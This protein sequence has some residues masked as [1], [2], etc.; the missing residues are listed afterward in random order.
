M[1]DPSPPPA[2]TA[3]EQFLTVLPRDEALA[4]FEAAL[5][6]I[7]FATEER[8]LAEALGRVLAEDIAAPVDVPPFDRSGVDGFAVRAADLAEAGEAPAGRAFAQ[9]R[10]DRLRP[11]RGSPVAAGRRRRSPPAG[12]CRAAP[13]PW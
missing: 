3:Q 12:R 10:D 5:G 2:G 11:R 6:P 13:T 9:R 7:D 1:T 4:R 8:A